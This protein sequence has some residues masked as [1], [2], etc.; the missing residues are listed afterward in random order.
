MASK[1]VTI[2]EFIIPKELTLFWKSAC[3]K[4]KAVVGR[5]KV[6]IVSKSSEKKTKKII[7]DM[8]EI[9]NAKCSKVTLESC[10]TTLHKDADALSLNVKT[11]SCWNS[12][13]SY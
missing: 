5:S 10:F 9:I 12:K 3:I 13:N 2:Q 6:E 1:N 11:G 8:N 4:Y 7:K